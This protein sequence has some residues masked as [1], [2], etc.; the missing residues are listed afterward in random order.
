MEN[1]TPGEFLCF[2]KINSTRK[3]PNKH[4]VLFM[5]PR[6]EVSIFSGVF[7]KTRR[8]KLE[9]Y[10]AV[11]V[12]FHPRPLRKDLISHVLGVSRSPFPKSNTS[13]VCLPRSKIL[14]LPNNTP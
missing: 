8:G 5:I 9:K 6:T 2:F 10:G 14:L 12:S 4:K 13:Y 11:W 1:M 3:A 7:R